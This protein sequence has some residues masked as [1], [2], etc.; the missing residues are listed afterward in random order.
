MASTPQIKETMEVG[1]HMITKEQYNMAEEQWKNLYHMR[2]DLYEQLAFVNSAMKE[3][4]DKYFK[5]E[6]GEY[7]ND[8]RET[9]T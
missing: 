8:Y 4:E 7:K 5:L 2:N 1:F 6:G 9:S 3:I